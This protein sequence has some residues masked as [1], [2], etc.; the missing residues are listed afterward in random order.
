MRERWIDGQRMKG[1]IIGKENVQN[2]SE[3]DRWTENE[4][5]D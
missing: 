4:Q 5:M 1:W 2:V 3:M